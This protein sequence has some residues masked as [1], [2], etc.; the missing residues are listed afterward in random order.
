MLII[1]EFVDSSNKG[2]YEVF[3]VALNSNVDTPRIIGG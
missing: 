2:G 1:G 3:E